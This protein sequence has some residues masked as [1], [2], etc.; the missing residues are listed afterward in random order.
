MT[1]ECLAALIET[2]SNISNI[3]ML[4]FL[5]NSETQMLEIIVQANNMHFECSFLTSERA[6]TRPSKDFISGTYLLTSLGVLRKDYLSISTTVY[7][8]WGFE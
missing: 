1:V 8:M 5:S 2:L 7:V 6:R 4:Q 3:A